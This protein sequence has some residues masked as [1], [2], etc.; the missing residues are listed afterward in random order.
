MP[1]LYSESLSQNKTF[2]LYVVSSQGFGHG[3][4]SNGVLRD[5]KRKHSFLDMKSHDDRLIACYDLIGTL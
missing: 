1:F 3:N 2:V 4:K 5:R